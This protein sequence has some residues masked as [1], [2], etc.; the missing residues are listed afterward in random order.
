MR[1]KEAGTDSGEEVGVKAKASKIQ[2]RK[3]RHKKRLGKLPPKPLKELIFCGGSSGI[4]TRDNRIKSAMLI[5][6]QLIISNL[7]KAFPFADS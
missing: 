5:Q 6:K 7:Q 4:R 2:A 3:K 1:E